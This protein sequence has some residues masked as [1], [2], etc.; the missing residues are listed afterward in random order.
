M[1]DIEDLQEKV[2]HLETYH[3]ELEKYVKKQTLVILF[4]FG[5]FVIDKIAKFWI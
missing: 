2:R 5:L 3:N 4:L 1:D